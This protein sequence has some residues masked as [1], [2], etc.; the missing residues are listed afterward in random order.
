[1]ADSRKLITYFIYFS[2]WWKMFSTIN[3]LKSVV[4][5]IMEIVKNVCVLYCISDICKG[6]VA[7][8]N[9]I[10]SINQ[11]IYAPTP[12]IEVLKNQVQFRN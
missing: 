7:Q 1:M 2:L 9:K 5:E 3:Y 8:S 10:Q 4:C 12:P 11:S 6:Q